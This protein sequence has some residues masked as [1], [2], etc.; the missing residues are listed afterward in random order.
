M[1]AKPSPL[2]DKLHAHLKVNKADNFSHL[3]QEQL[4]PIVVQE[5]IDVASEFPIIF[6]KDA[7]SGKFLAVAMMGLKAQENLYCSAGSW[8]ANYAPLALQ[9]YPFSLMQDANNQQLLVCINENSPLVNDAEGEAL[10]EPDGQQTK[11]LQQKSAHLLDYMEKSQMTAGFVELLLKHHLLVP[12]NLSIKLDNNETFNANG[13]YVID[14]TVLDALSEQVFQELRQVGALQA[15][16]AQLSSMKQI[17]R[18]TRK[19]LSQQ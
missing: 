18:L 3:S 7:N 5:F 16:Y 12:R 10:F 4:I 17:H 11:Y 1:I 19:K 2:N 14:H 6:V 9:N 8:Q 15:I 13:I